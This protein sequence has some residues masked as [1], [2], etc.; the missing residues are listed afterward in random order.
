MWTPDLPEPTA[1]LRQGDLLV[2][3]ALPTLKWPL[4]YARPPREDV[5]G[6]QPV[7]VPSGKVQPHLV[8]SQCCTIENKTVAAL[9]RVRPTRPRT[10]DEARDLE[11]EFPSDDPEV[12]YSF[13]EHALKPV[14]G[15][16]EREG[17]LIWVA[18]F[19]SIQTYSGSIADFQGSRVAAMSPEGRRALRV[20]LG[21]FWA[22]VEAEDEQYLTKRGMSTGFRLE[23][24]AAVPATTAE[25]TAH[26]TSCAR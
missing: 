12:S 6:E 21:G 25:P 17:G 24:V 23:F 1:A 2:D 16:L 7:L 9:A 15:H 22:R 13:V 20:R 8:V 26:A 3:L 10:A 18:D 19:T 5:S 11:R 14:G 4:H